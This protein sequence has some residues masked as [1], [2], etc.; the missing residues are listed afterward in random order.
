MRSPLR[1]RFELRCGQHHWLHGFQQWGVAFTVPAIHYTGTSVGVVSGLYAPA[2]GGGTGAL[3]QVASDNGVTITGLSADGW[4]VVLPAARTKT[5]C[6]DNV[7]PEQDQFSGCVDSAGA[8]A[9]LPAGWTCVRLGTGNYTVTHNLGLNAVRDLVFNPTGEVS[10]AVVVWS[11]TESTTAV[12]RIRTT[13]AGAAADAAFSFITR[14]R[15]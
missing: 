4:S 12:A 5:I 7:E 8:S 3:V 13:I 1:L 15:R 14:R 2:N 10:D 11:V 9:G 6:T